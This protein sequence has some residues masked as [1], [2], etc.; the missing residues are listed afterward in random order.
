M[1]IAQSNEILRAE[2]IQ[3]K[4]AYRFSALVVAVACF[5]ALVVSCIF[6][7]AWQRLRIYGCG[8]VL[9]IHESGLL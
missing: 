2:F 5:L 8:Q 3:D 7:L 9:P 4:V 6:H 1:P